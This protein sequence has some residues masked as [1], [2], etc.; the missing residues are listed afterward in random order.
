[1]WPTV[2]GRTKVRESVVQ[3]SDSWCCKWA[4]VWQTL[5]ATRSGHIQSAVTSQL[6]VQPAALQ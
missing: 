1:M 2:S 6:I 4:I 3:C 5:L